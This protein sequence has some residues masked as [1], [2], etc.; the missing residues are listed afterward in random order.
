MNAPHRDAQQSGSPHSDAPHRDAR[1][2][3]AAGLSEAARARSELYTTLGQLR[4]R[5]DYA[6]RIDDSVERAKARLAEG[7]RK[8]PTGYAIGAVA[9]AVGIGAVVW[10]VARK[11][12]NR[13]D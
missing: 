1:Q 6:Q 11:V 4:E 8:N 2:S 7:R 13:F 9:L 10:V 12:V 5:L 3:A